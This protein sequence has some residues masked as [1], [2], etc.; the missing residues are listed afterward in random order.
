MRQPADAPRLGYGLA[1][2]YGNEGPWRDKPG[3][4][5]LAQSVSGALWLSGDRD[6]PPTPMGLAV[7]D[8]LAELSMM[9]M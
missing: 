9:R 5:L 1:T 4:D 3:Q 2:G 7:A 6:D 8:M